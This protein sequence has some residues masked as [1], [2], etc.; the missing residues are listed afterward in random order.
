MNVYNHIFQ[1]K[2]LTWQP[3]NPVILSK[4]TGMCIRIVR[5]KCNGLQFKK[6]YMGI[7][8]RCHAFIFRQ[9]VNAA[10]PR[11]TSLF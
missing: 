8:K 10:D 6:V 4:H 11:C 7:K 2:L 1:Q 9:Y 3:L 5:N